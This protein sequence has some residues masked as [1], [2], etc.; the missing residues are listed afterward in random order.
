ML[1]RSWLS[2]LRSRLVLLTLV[3]LIS[4]LAAAGIAVFVGYRHDR[5]EVETHLQE[6]ARALSLGSARV[7]MVLGTA[8]H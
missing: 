2:P 4:A 7:A 3:L 1:T 8:F 5:R 6:T